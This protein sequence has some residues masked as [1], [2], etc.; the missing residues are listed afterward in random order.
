MLSVFLS[1]A[2]PS[3]CCSRRIKA[4]LLPSTGPEPTSYSSGV[5]HNV[6]CPL[7]HEEFSVVLPENK[8]ASKTLQVHVW[9]VGDDGDEECL[10]SGRFVTFLSVQRKLVLLESHSGTLT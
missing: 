3:L 2:E 6:N 10:V 9:S 4:A 1:Q 5:Q 8:L 7:F